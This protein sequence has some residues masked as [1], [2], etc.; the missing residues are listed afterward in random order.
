[1]NH[2]LP[3]ATVAKIHA[4]LARH[5]EVERAVLYG[6]R[7]KGNYKTGSDIDLTLFGEGLGYDDLL[8]LTGELDDLLLPYMIDLSIFD[9]LHHAGLRDHIE[10][11]GQIFYEQ[12]PLRVREDS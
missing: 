9:R 3:D 12:E 10:R 1:M 8:K 7:A 5:P 6:S 11:V 4:V 2:G